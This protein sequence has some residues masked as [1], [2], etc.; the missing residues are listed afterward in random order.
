MI[1]STRYGVELQ[2]GTEKDPPGLANRARLCFNRFHESAGFIPSLL[3]AT[4]RPTM[5]ATDKESRKRTR[6]AQDLLLGYLQGALLPWPGGDGL[7]IDDI[8]GS[9]CVAVATGRAPDAHALQADHP[10]LARELA[11]LLR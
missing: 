1:Q 7:T 8:L 6:L 11:S 10:E 3:D 2:Q 4:A 9:Y 5:I